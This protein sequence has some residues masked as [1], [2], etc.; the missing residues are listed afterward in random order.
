MSFTDA[1]LQ[2]P[3]RESVF[4]IEDEDDLARL[5]TFNLRD[6]GF[7]V[8]S[9]ADGASGLAAI[10]ER[11]PAVVVLDLMLPGM[12]GTEV[13]RRIRA[14]PA[15]AHTGVLMMTAKGE[16]VDRVVSFELGADDYVVKPFSIRELV[17]RVR[18][19]VRRL[20]DHDT[21]PDPDSSRSQLRWRG[22]EV[23]R[24]RHRVSVDGRGV[25]LRPMEYRLLTV[26]L[27]ANGATLERRKILELVWPGSSES[28]GRAIDSTVRR[29]R[30]ALGK[31]GAAIETV[32][33][34]GYKLADK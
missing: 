9:S 18:A 23:D 7:Q 8:H 20:R 26:I 12:P 15:L 19:L 34:V 28:S 27:E 22:L 16:E 1:L 29:L 5:V 6:A 11:P 30:S 13:L 17:L 33:G 14:A 32:Y 4:V 21:F 2:P 24:V 25:E 31:A 3:Q 10:F